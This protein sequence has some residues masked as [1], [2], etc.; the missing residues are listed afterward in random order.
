MR[1]TLILSML[2][3]L[4]PSMAIAAD[5]DA[6]NQL[7]V[8]ATAYTSAIDETASHAPGITAWGHRLEPGMKVIA[9]SRDLIQKG[10][11]YNTRVRIKGLE[12]TYRVLDKMHPRWRNKI[13]IFMGTDK[14]KALHWGKRKVI[15]T[16][17][18][19]S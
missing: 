17:D 7:E 5:D 3:I 12:G 19:Q 6:A 8:T 4:L 15:I 18:S 2:F 13:D 14:Q 10:L 16:W 1:Y 9:V 11:T